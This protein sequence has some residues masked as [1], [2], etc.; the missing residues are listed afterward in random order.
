MA[1]RVGGP[2]RIETVVLISES[3]GEPCLMNILMGV[4]QGGRES[5]SCRNSSDYFFFR[6]PEEPKLSGLDLFPI[7][8]I[9]FPDLAEQD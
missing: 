4:G 8:D 3:S 6:I 9:S 1:R 5:P 7:G 2:V